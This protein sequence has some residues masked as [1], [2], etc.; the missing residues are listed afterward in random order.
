MRDLNECNG[1]N[2]VVVDV[3]ICGAFIYLAYSMIQSN[4]KL[5]KSNWIGYRNWYE[6][7]HHI[8]QINK[9]ETK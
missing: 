2:V 9:C 8:H 7:D 1:V 3:V 4:F 6:L 5:S